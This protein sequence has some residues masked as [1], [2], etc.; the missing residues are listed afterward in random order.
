MGPM[1]ALQNSLQ[2]TGSAT[3]CRPHG[4][5]GRERWEG[6]G[7][8]TQTMLS[9][10]VAL[11]VLLAWSFPLALTWSFPL[12]VHLTWTFPPAVHLIT[13]VTFSWVTLL[14]FNM[15]KGTLSSLGSI[16][17]QGP[18]GLASGCLDLFCVSPGKIRVHGARP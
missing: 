7:S 5:L 12:V 14:T 1:G 2:I 16:T 8:L 13:N 18:L 17:L 15:E 11:L 9:A 10:E 4:G 6:A 3:Q